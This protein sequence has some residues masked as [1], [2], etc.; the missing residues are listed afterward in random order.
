MEFGYR[1]L[2]VGGNLNK[3]QSD[4]NYKTGPRVFDTSFLVKG[5][6]GAAIDTFLVTTTGGGDPHGHMRVSLENSKWFRFDGSYRRFKYFSALNN[7]A[8]PNYAPPSR[9]S[10]PVQGWHSMDIRQQVGDFD[11]TLLPKNNRVRFNFGYSPSRYSGPAYTSWHYGGDDFQLLTQTRSKSDDFRFGADWRPRE[12]RLW[13]RDMI[14]KWKDAADVWRNL[15]YYAGLGKSKPKIERFGYA[16]KAEY[17]AV[18]WGTI[19]MGLTGLVIWFKVGLFG[20]LPR[21]WVDVSI[22]V[23]FYEAVLAT[24]AIVVWHVY[25]V[26]FD[27]DVYPVNFAFY[28]GKVSEE[29]YKEEHESDYERMK[30]KA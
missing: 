14:P 1:G 5:K 25:H 24:L 16:E 27:P 10:D 12:G 22:A 11:L 29:L 28:D 9:Q 17:W 18:V 26:A 2:R 3:Y 8:N 20:F 30:E 21:W 23:H 15:L 6:D 13:V 7:I 4:L 19:I